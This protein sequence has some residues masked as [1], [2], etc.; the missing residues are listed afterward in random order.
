[1]TN[2]EKPLDFRNRHLSGGRALL[3]LAALEVAVLLTLL[4]GWGFVFVRVHPLAERDASEGG[5][6]GDDPVVFVSP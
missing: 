4:I 3:R 2:L 5:A 6:K 1:M